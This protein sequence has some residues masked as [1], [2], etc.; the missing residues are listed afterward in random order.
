M[1]KF[2]RIFAI[3]ILALYFV[4]EIASGLVFQMQL[5]GFIITAV[6]MALATK[7]IRPIVNILLLP[8][9]LATLGL[10]KF[11]SHTVT[12]YLVDF[13]LDEFKVV[14]FH[15]PGL[16]STYLD[17]PPITINS[18]IGAYLAFSLLISVIA[19]FVNWLSK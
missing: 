12:L 11:L 13:A 18:P 1:R 10:F 15:F 17:L 7:L 16:V 14:G 5:E 19:G 9:N 8:L 2:F 3:E 6:A 4:N